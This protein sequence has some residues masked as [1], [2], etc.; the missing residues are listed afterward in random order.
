[1]H[2][3]TRRQKCGAEIQIAT[4]S[5]RRARVS[6]GFGGAAIFGFRDG[7]EKFCLNRSDAKSKGT[8]QR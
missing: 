4:D 6:T 8:T 2:G 1:M 5:D 3:H 7:P